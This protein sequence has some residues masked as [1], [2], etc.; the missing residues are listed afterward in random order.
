[1]FFYHANHN[2]KDLDA[3]IAFYRD[4]LGLKKVDYYNIEDGA[5]QLA[6]MGD[7]RGMMLEL[8]CVQEDRVTEATEFYV[9]QHKL[10]IPPEK[11]PFHIAFYS[12]DYENDLAKHQAMGIVVDVEEE[13]GVYFIKDPEGYL[14]E[15]GN[16]AL[17]DKQK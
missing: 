12:H 11:M 3:S 10:D 2:V 16:G 8:T 6:F 5:M 9:P 4:V 7:E 17:Y 15:I 13:P 14:V 1:M